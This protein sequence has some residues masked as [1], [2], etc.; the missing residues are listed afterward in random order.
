[1]KR[2]RGVR[3]LSMTAC[4][5]VFT[6]FTA[7]AP[8]QV[9]AQEL[10]GLVLL[11]D[12]V[13]PAPGV[14]AVLIHA[15]RPDSIVARGL[16]NDRGRFTLKIPEST[17]TVLRLLRIGFEPMQGGTFTLARGE[18]FEASFTLHDN[19]V[20]LATYDV[21][22][23]ARCQVQ[24]NGAQLVAQLFQQARTA[25]IASTTSLSGTI[26]AR[27]VNYTR[28]QNRRQQLLTP[29]QRSTLSNSTLRPYSSIGVDSLEKVGYVVDDHGDY[30]FY[31]PD[32]EVLLSDRFLT[33]HCLQLV[34]GTDS[35]AGSIGIG[36]R[37][38]AARRNHVDIQGTLWLDRGTSELQFLEYTYTSLPDLLKSAELGGRV[39]YAHIP[40]GGWFVNNWFIRM[41]ILASQPQLTVAASTIR[42]PNRVVVSGLQ[43]SGGEVQDIRVDD[44]VLYLNANA[45]RAGSRLGDAAVTSATTTGAG[46]LMHGDSATVSSFCGAQATFEHEGLIAGRVFDHTHALFEGAS[47]KAE[48][49][50]D[51]RINSSGFQWANREVSTTS[52]SAGTYFLCGIAV[53]RTIS[54]V[55][56][57]NDRWGRPSLVRVTEE[58]PSAQLDLTLD[59]PTAK[60]KDVSRR[61]R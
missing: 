25:L 39:E 9:R 45:E 31:A 58:S 6:L 12:G 1:M 37:P 35:L 11:P 18:V 52:S 36:F 17:A 33:Q 51:F 10:R 46:F 22:A 4:A 50:E 47:V 23:T 55:A 29:V 56:G 15:T 49:K 34:N 26:S 7:F 44:Q 13:T 53:R 24:P 61:E 14:V 2:T 32:A 16:T 60:Q 48:W 3:R 57:R 40:N 19:H 41:P 59:P 20:K 42:S 21:R 38:T 54:V 8:I 28:Q 27:A 5:T 43:I 30:N